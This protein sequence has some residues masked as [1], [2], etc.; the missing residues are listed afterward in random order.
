VEAGPGKGNMTSNHLRGFEMELDLDSI[1]TVDTADIELL[2]PITGESTGAFVTLAGPEHQQ[3]KAEVMAIL[4][5][6]RVRGVQQAQRFARG[7]KMDVQDPEE[8]ERESMDMLARSILGWRGIKRNGQL[9]AFSAQAVKDLLSD[10][11]CAWIVK[12]LLRAMN[13]DELFIKA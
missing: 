7:G 8:D 6:Q 4:R 5:R 13:N 11:K 1:A 9:V 2:H 10:P 3:R 12:Q